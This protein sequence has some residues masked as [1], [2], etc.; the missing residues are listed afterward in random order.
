MGSKTDEDFCRKIA[1][2]CQKYNL[3][4]HLRVSSAHKSTENVFQILN[5]Y[6]GF[7]LFV[8]YSNSC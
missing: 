2:Y 6:N 5:E 1:D 3:C 8:F 7:C 4:Y